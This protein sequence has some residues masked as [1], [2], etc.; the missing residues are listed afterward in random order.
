MS[1]SSTTP[2]QRIAALV[3]QAVL[4]LRQSAQAQLVLALELQQC[5]KLIESRDE[6][7]TRV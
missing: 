3:G 4:R 5:L 7:G 2:Q 6:K 1:A